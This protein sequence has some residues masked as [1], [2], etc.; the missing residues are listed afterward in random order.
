MRGSSFSSADV[1]LEDCFLERHSPDVEA[2]CA[3]LL[4]P[5]GLLAEMRCGPWTLS[6]PIPV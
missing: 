4:T 5:S 1:M 3:P 6:Y 2:G